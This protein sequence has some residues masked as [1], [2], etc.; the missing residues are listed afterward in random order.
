[1]SHWC[2]GESVEP[3]AAGSNSRTVYFGA[4]FSVLSRSGAA[5]ETDLLAGRAPRGVRD[6]QAVALDQLEQPVLVLDG[7]QRRGVRRGEGQTAHV[8][9]LGPGGRGERADLV[10]DRDVRNQP[11][12]SAQRS[13]DGL[14]PSVAQVTE[15]TVVP[16]ASRR[17][18]ES[19]SPRPTVE[20]KVT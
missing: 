14:A 15:S 6:P 3:A 4:E 2:S 8:A 20:S 7:P 5:R 10:G 1:M 17:K 18:S 13:S 19:L 16:P 12:P 11:V 9:A